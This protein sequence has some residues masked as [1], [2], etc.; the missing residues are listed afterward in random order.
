MSTYIIFACIFHIEEYLRFSIIVLPYT[1]ISMIVYFSYEM[2]IQKKVTHIYSICVSEA[3]TLY[4][5]HKFFHTILSYK[6]LTL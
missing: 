2:L 3:N 5:Y 4:Q 1:I 6:M